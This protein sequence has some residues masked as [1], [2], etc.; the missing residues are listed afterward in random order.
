[1]LTWHSLEM[2]REQMPLKFTPAVGTSNRRT[3]FHQC[4]LS[5]S[6]LYAGKTTQQSA[7]RRHAGSNFESFGSRVWLG[8]NGGNDSDSVFQA[9]SECQ[10]QPEIFTKNAL[11]QAKSRRIV[12]TQPSLK[13]YESTPEPKVYTPLWYGR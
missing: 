13:T 11:G 2:L 6:Y 10:I 12:Y 7:A 8:R 1:M 9:G 3:C 4:N 5:N